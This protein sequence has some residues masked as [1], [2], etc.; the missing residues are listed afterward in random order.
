MARH[1]S[2]IDPAAPARFPIA[3]GEQIGGHISVFAS[4]TLCRALHPTVHGPQSHCVYTGFAG[5]VLDGAGDELRQCCRARGWRAWVPDAVASL[6]SRLLTV[7]RGKRMAPSAR[8]ASPLECGRAGPWYS[9]YATTTPA[10]GLTPVQDQQLG[11]LIMRI[12]GGLIYLCVALALMLAWLHRSEREAIGFTILG[13]A[14]GH[15][16]LGRG[17]L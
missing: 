3:E 10:W 4:G 14:E 13:D 9:P 8:C 17:S 7:V 16:S 11:G 1:R 15:S 5:S 6:E 2:K 12:P